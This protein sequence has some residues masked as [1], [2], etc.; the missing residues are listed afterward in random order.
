M[1]IIKVI[2]YGN[3]ESRFYEKRKGEQMVGEV[4]KVMSKKDDLNSLD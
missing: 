4:I 3:K 1:N 2:L